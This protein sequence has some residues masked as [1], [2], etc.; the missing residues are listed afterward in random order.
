MANAIGTSRT[1][2][3]AA[4]L[5]DD[6]PTLGTAAGIDDTLTLGTEDA[7]ATGT[8]IDTAN[9]NMGPLTMSYLGPTM[10]TVD[11][12]HPQA[13]T[14]RRRVR[15]PFNVRPEKTCP[16]HRTH[17]EPHLKPYNPPWTP[18]CQCFLPNTGPM[19]GWP[20]RRQSFKKIPKPTY[21]P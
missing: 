13:T 2:G 5:I 19:S 15:C 8:V 7:H 14:L 18:V 4:G 1:T 6:A 17:T 10:S 16:R 20:P 9:Q 21:Q 12:A 3:T 11:V